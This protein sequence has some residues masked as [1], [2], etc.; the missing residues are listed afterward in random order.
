MSVDRHTGASVISLGNTFHLDT[1]DRCHDNREA[2]GG[3]A[4]MAASKYGRRHDPIRGKKYERSPYW[5]SVHPVG[6][7][8]FNR[9][10]FD[11]SLNKHV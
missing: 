4:N 3:P 10:A 5:I 8:L 2:G 6:N 11:N 1:P 9:D 7:D